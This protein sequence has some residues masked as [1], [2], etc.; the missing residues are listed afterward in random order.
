MG[1]SAQ[2]EARIDR[3]NRKVKTP[4][5]SSVGSPVKRAGRQTAQ[6]ANCSGKQGWRMHPAKVE[7]CSAG[8]SRWMR[9]SI[10]LRVRQVN[11]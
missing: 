3:T 5:A 4:N 11:G 8:A 7:G 6:A 2:A 1:D 10:R 9:P